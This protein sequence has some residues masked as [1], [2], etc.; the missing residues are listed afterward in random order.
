MART[1]RGFGAAAGAAAAAAVVGLPSEPS[2]PVGVVE[3]LVIFAMVV[4]R[5]MLIGADL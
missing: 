1:A 3:A 5:S 2:L 4:N